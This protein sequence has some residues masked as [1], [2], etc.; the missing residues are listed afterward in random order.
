MSEGVAHAQAASVSQTAL[1]VT[2]IWCSYFFA[3]TVCCG[4]ALFASGAGWEVWTTL[5][6]T[7]FVGGVAAVFATVAWLLL[8]PLDAGTLTPLRP[9]YHVACVMGCLAVLGL[10]A[11]VLGTGSVSEALGGI[12]LLCMLGVPVLIGVSLGTFVQTQRVKLERGSPAK[13]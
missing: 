5:G 1:R 3:V 10:V 6:M 8:H 11:V 9:V 2:G 13:P 4:I 12:L 7:A